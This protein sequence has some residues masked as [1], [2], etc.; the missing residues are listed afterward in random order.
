[1]VTH[2]IFDLEYF[3]SEIKRSKI[4]LIY[5]NFLIV[6]YSCFILTY[7]YMLIINMRNDTFVIHTI[8]LAVVSIVLVVFVYMY[9][10]L[11]KEKIKN[12]NK[13]KDKYDEVLKSIDYKKYINGKR[14]AKLKK[15]KWKRIF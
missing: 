8:I 13:S 6:M 7:G 4:E 10:K 1:M 5:V 12:L 15:I 3:K 2:T 14:K 9:I 11:R